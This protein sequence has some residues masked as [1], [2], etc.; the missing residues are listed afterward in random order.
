LFEEAKKFGVNQMYITGGEP[1]IRDDFFNILYEAR[2]RFKKTIISSNGFYIDKNASIE[3]KRIKPDYVMLSL[4]S[5]SATLHDQNR[6]LDGLHN[7]VC[8]AIE[9]LSSVNVPVRINIT[10]TQ[11][12]YKEIDKLAYLSKELG[13]E[14]VLFSTFMPVGRGNKHTSLFLNDLQINEIE[15]EIEVIKKRQIGV[16]IKYKR[17]KQL[18]VALEECPGADSYYY[19][20]A[21]GKIAPCPW[22]CRLDDKFISTIT[23]KDYSFFELVKSDSISQFRDFVKNRNQT[24]KC[25]PCNITNC[26]HGCPAL[27]KIYDHDYSG[28]D[29]YCWEYRK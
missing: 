10:V 18:G 27:A 25:T 3:L 9:L 5:I 17:T 6:K 12:N 13:A 15:N 4:D 8:A 21:E 29:P 23:L 19:I 24:H 22:I 16:E 26:G 7:K 20:T 1:L 2:K 11:F 28:F 14:M